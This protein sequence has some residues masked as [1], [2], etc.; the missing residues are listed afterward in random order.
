MTP[1]CGLRCCTLISDSSKSA[2]IFIKQ[3]ALKKIE[4]DLNS[5]LNLLFK[6]KQKSPPKVII[7]GNFLRI[8][9]LAKKLF[10]SKFKHV[11]INLK[12]FDSF[13]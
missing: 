8:F 6:K 7:F 4:L 9:D 1:Y 13:Y 3:L 12:L 2:L 5:K 11:C 10:L